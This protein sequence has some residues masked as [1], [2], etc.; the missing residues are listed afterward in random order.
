MYFVV[1]P[2]INNMVSPVL[3]FIRLTGRVFGDTTKT[4]KVFEDTTYTNAVYQEHKL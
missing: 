2:I 1:S 4:I 3:S